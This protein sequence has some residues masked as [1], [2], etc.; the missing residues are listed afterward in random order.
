[1]S[2]P[3]GPLETWL[4]A[5]LGTK[6]L[7]VLVDPDR[8]PQGGLEALGRAAAAAGVDGFLAGS[9]LV[10]ED[11]LGEQVARLKAASGLPTILFPGDSG[12]VVAPAD[13]LLFLSLVSGR[14]PQ[15]LIGEHVRSAPRIARLGLECLPTAYMLVE[16]G[17]VTSAQFMSGSQPLPRNKPDIAVAHALAAKALGLRQ[18]YLEAGSGA[19]LPVPLE[20]IAAV[21]AVFDGPLF[22]GGGLRLP[23]EAAAAAKAGADCVV[24]G[25]RVED[26]KAEDWPALL[27][28]LAQAVH[29]A[30]DSR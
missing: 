11:G 30:G 2:L 21:K 6:R 1:M 25:S 12:Q 5:G 28:E 7:F 19:K 18:L 26:A 27:A 17:T 24:V 14:N 4:R 8:A 22:V 15:Y 23:A 9:S 10:L 29:S 13:G 16:S 3:L 20:M